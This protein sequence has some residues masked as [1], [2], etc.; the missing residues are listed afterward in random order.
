[1]KIKNLQDVRAYVAN[2]RKSDR[3]T[4]TFGDNANGVYKIVNN[5]SVSDAIQAA[6]GVIRVYHGNKSEI[7]TGEQLIEIIVIE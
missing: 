1:M 4:I 2:S 5:M 7:K 6:N 3:T